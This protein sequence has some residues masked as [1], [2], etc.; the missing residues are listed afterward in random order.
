MKTNKLICKALSLVAL[1]CLGQTA[2]WAQRITDY[3]GRTIQHKQAKWHSMRGTIS[4]AAK[5]LDTFNDDEKMFRN[6]YTGTEI[7]AAHTYY[8][9]LYV[10]KGDDVTL[11]LPLVSQSYNASSNKQV[12]A[13]AYQRWYNFVTERTFSYTQYGS[14]RD[15]LSPSSNCLRYANQQGWI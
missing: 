9:T 10:R 2:A 7:Q 3:S 8:D 13:Q 5:A 11:T 4:E 14:T 15:I 6:D 12:S 1:L